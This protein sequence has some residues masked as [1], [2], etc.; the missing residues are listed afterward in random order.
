M[1]VDELRAVDE[2]LEVMNL[3]HLEQGS[4]RWRSWRCEGLGGSDIAAI[5]GLSPYK[6][7]SPEEVFAEKTSR[8]AKE[9]TFAMRRGIRLEP[10]AREMVKLRFQRSFDP[11]CVEHGE[12]PW[13]RASLDGICLRGKPPAL[14]EIKAPKWTDHDRILCGLVPPHF[15][16]QMQWQMLVTGV[17]R[18]HLV[19]ISEK[20]DMFKGPDLLAHVEVESDPEQQAEILDVADAFWQRVLEHRAGR[21]PAEALA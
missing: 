9:S 2:R 13:M 3:I 11:C 20:F 1:R 7:A 5:M 17:D 8:Q 21:V 4:D 19:S 10:R 15:M 14:L 12:Q 6:D 16:V 18:C